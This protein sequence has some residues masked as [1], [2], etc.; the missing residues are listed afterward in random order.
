MA[1]DDRGVIIK[2]FKDEPIDPQADD[3]YVPLLRD[4]CSSPPPRF[5][6]VQGE[7][8]FVENELVE[9]PVGKT[10][11]T[12][13]MA[14]NVIRRLASRYRDEQN[15]SM[16]L[17]TRVRTPT[18]VL[19]CDVLAHESIFG[20]T[21]PSA[22]VYSDLFG[23]ALR[24]GPA[25]DR[26][27]ISSVHTVEFLGRGPGAAHTPEIPRYA[28]MLQHVMDRLSWDGPRFN[29][30][31]VRIEFPFTPTS[32]VVSFGLLPRPT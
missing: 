32:L 23:D 7:R 26:Y 24:R 25:R 31:R 22:G 29:A 3:D 30:Y 27:R 11:A 12:T 10:G 16:D 13:L 4:F 19:V 21:T 9:G 17:V 5:R 14:G 15:T 18:A 6:R 20:D 1:T 2:P 8:G 28:R